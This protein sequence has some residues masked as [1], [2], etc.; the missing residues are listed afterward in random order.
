MMISVS[1]QTP[2]EKAVS[3]FNH[4]H[5]KAVGLKA[6]SSIINNCISILEAELKKGSLTEKIAWYHLLALNFKARFVLSDE[7]D[8]KNL[9]DRAALLA[10]TYCHK[11]P[12]S[13]PILFEYIT[14]IG[15]R[16]EITGIL[17]NATNG[18]VEKMRSSAQQLVKLDS[19][20]GAGNGW[21]V[22]GILYCKTP[23]VP[24]VITW[25][26]KKISLKTLEKALH[27]FPAD[28]PNNFYYAEALLESKET[29]KAR[30]YFNLVLKLKGR[31]YEVLEDLDFRIKATNYL[32]NL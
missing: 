25:P 32:K 15:L 27:Y 18:V 13:G 11:F 20:Y 21:K 5:E 1:A 24:L 30:I 29:E 12:L 26:D 2:V 17:A 22:L 7:K 31:E 23:Y 8:K 6:D 16:A 19:M 3:L 28:I 10:E 9:L 14:S 4:R